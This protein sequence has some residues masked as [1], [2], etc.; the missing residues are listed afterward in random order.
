MKLMYSDE[1]HSTGNMNLNED[2]LVS[3]NYA[4]ENLRRKKHK[5]NALNWCLSITL[6]S[7]H[8]C[9]NQENRVFKKYRLITNDNDVKRKTDEILLTTDLKFIII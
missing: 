6:D 2:C 7:Y 8:I 4:R 9:N 1:F 3:N 5:I